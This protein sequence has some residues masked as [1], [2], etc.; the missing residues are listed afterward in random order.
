MLLLTSRY[1][2][3]ARRFIVRAELAC[4]VVTTLTIAIYYQY[5]THLCKLFNGPGTLQ[6]YLYCQNWW[7]TSFQHMTFLKAF[8]GG[9][10][11][12][13]CAAFIYQVRKERLLKV[14]S[15]RSKIYARVAF[16]K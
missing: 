1:G 5:L 6:G 7:R 14:V 16:R 15:C 9:L 10:N 3:P 8:V 4:L 11:T 12:L 2:Q 13:S